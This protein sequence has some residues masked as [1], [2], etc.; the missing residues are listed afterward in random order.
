[1][2]DSLFETIRY[3]IAVVL[4]AVL[5]GSWQPGPGRSRSLWPVW[6]GGATV[7]LLLAMLYGRYD[8]RTPV[9]GIV[10]LATVPLLGA[11]LAPASAVGRR[12]L[13]VAW[14]VTAFLVTA[15]RAAAVGSFA[16]TKAPDGVQVINSDL[17]QFYGGILLGVALLATAGITLARLRAH[18]GALRPF[19]TGPASLLLAGEHLTW[20]YYA[21]VLHGWLLLPESLFTP[22]TFAVNHIQWLGDGQLALAVFL[23]L[24]C[25]WHRD[26]PHEAVL[27][28]LG[29]AVRRKYL[30]NTRSQRRY[31][32]V[33]LATIGAIVFVAAY[34]R[35]YA[36]QPLRRTP[37]ERLE[38]TGGRLTIAIQRFAPEEFHRYVYADGEGHDIRFLVFKDEAG[39]IRA[40]YD[41]C[42]LCGTKGYLKRGKE[43]ICL[44][45]GAAIYAPTV[46]RSGGCNPVP[47]PHSMA[48]GTLV[49]QVDALLHGDGADAFRDGHGEA[50]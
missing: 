35:L 30:W 20:G 4:V 31:G 45:C 49:V 8:V 6:T 33:F 19:A 44:A 25:V 13:D 42:V 43:L 39:R 9:E 28:H 47:L 37:A 1:M 2:I 11:L 16:L 50:R 38:A 32:V 46:G 21:L 18:E 14:R 5:R 7:G 26:R 17:L 22:T 15:Q 41:A 3:G 36:N 10:M 24:W 29:P 23:G 34:Y 27:V 40:A 48:D 12:A